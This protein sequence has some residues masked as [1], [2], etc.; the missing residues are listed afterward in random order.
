MKKIQCCSSSCEYKRR[1]QTCFGTNDYWHDEAIFEILRINPEER[2]KNLEEKPDL[3]NYDVAL[4]LAAADDLK[5]ARDVMEG[6]N[7][8]SELSVSDFADFEREAFKKE[9]EIYKTKVLHDRLFYWLIEEN[10]PQPEIP[11]G[12]K[13]YFREI[14]TGWKKLGIYRDGLISKKELSKLRFIDY[15]CKIGETAWIIEGKQKLNPEAIKQIKE[16]YN[17]FVDDNPTLKVKKAIVCEEANSK[18]KDV[19]RENNIEVFS[20][21]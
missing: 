16:Y 14:A 11:R 20:L 19:C 5:K 1:Q 13:N 17:L 9:L 21:R 2:I 4:A 10:L 18:L 3:K 15:V 12:D 6:V 7:V 8:K